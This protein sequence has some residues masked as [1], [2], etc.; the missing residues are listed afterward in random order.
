MVFSCRMAASTIGKPVRPSHHAAKWSLSYDQEMFEYSGLKGLFMLLMSVVE[1]VCDKLYL[2]DIWPVNQNMLI[3]V[4]P[5]NFTDPSL[6]TVV[7]SIQF[8]G[9]VSVARSSHACPC[10]DGSSS[11]MY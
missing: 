3:K 9:F 11:Q 7:T 1:Q 8:L 2:P 5:G 6:N 4:A 10:T